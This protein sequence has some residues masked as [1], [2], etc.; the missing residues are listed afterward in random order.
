MIPDLVQ[1][2]EEIR[3]LCWGIFLDLSEAL[4]AILDEDGK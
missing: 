3:A 4:S 1:P 2:T